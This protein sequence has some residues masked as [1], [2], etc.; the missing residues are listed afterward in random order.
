MRSERDLRINQYY[1]Y[2]IFAKRCSQN[3]R[4]EIYNSICFSRGVP[5][6]FPKK[7][8]QKTRT[9]A[10]FKVSFLLVL[11]CLR[12]CNICT[13]SAEEG[14]QETQLGKGKHT[15]RRRRR[16]SKASLIRRRRA[17]PLSFQKSATKSSSLLLLTA[18]CRT[19]LSEKEGRKRGK[20]RR[21]CVSKFLTPC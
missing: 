16:R 2:N 13:E 1:Q 7:G 5:G 11:F 14:D 15:A 10:F 4:S 17:L 3:V 8:K 21:S 6:C 12:C 18:V 19:S 20:R 9:S